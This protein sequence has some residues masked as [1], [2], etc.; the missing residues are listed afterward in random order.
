MYL[1]NQNPWYLG[2]SLDLH[3]CHACIFSLISLTI[4]Y[5]RPHRSFNHLVDKVSSHIGL[6]TSIGDAE[7]AIFSSKLLAPDYQSMYACS[8]LKRMSACSC[9]PLFPL[10]IF[11]LL[12][13]EWVLLQI[14]YCLFPSFLSF[15]LFFFSNTW[16]ILFLSLDLHSTW[17]L[18]GPV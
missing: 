2:V 8:F 3:T 12:Y 10:L 13:Q 7:L 1:K 18:H 5:Y 17:S 4:I 15:F 6:L 11:L 16:W 14:C 9:K